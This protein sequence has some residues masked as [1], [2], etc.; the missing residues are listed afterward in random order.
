MQMRR[1]AR[2]LMGVALFLAG[3]GGRGGPPP[4]YLGHVDGNG[5]AE[6]GIRLAVVEQ[7][8]QAEQDGSA[9]V[10]VRHTDT[11]GKLEAFEAE[12]VR[13]VAVNNVKALLG[14]TTTAEVARLDRAQVPLVAFSGFRAR[15]M[16][17]LVFFTGLAPEF[18]G[19]VLAR[20]ALKELKAAR[21][22]VLVDESR[23]D[24]L[25]LAEAFSDTFAQ[26]EKQ[27]KDAQARPQT[28][29]YGKESK[30]QDWVKRLTEHKPQVVLVAGSVKDL[31]R[32][33]EELKPADRTV[34]LFGGE[35]GDSS[36]L[37]ESRA[38]E[39]AYLV[40]AFVR[41]ADT[42]RCHEFVDEFRK[43][44]SEDPDVLAALA[45]DGARLLFQ[46][47][48]TARNDPAPKEIAKALAEVKDFP[49]LTG[50]LTMGADHRLRRPAFVVTMEKGRRRTVRRFPAE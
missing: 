3:C 50:P 38:V 40:T 34:L 26:S 35:D 16:S 12:A 6:R 39:G 7:K 17:D 36:L 46:A 8:R 41:D 2:W 31:A 44:F 5:Q 25:A 14:G 1:N 22:A 18:Q 10:I 9:P 24:T 15:G 45:Y 42:S 11:R 47:L 49:G 4:I 37:Q 43:E 33:A 20:F 28:W 21:A 23:E 29:R 30:I 27:G 48:H 19:K 32:L 13:L